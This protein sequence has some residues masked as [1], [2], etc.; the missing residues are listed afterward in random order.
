MSDCLSSNV[1]Q[2]HSRRIMELQA[3]LA[4]HHGMDGEGH[5]ESMQLLVECDI[6][7]VKGVG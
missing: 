3:E 7:K 1:A 5:I 4:S 6:V 2:E